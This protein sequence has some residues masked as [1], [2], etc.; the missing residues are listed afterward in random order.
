MG[1]QGHGEDEEEEEEEDP[2]DAYMSAIDAEAEKQKKKAKDVESSSKELIAAGD[3]KRGERADIEEEDDQESFFRY[4]EENPNAGV[5]LTY[6]EDGVDIEYDKDGNPIPPER[7]KVIDPLPPIDHS[8]IEYRPFARNFYVEHE[9][10]AA[11]SS[12]EVA[13]LRSKFNIR[14]TGPSPPP[15]CSSFAHF[16]FNQQLMHAIKKSEYTQPTPIQA[17]AIPAG[18]AGRDIIGIAKTGSG[19][20]AAYLWP[21]LVHIMDQPELEPGDG[22]I[23]LIM[24][25]TRELSQQIQT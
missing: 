3:S 8:T 15:P 14:V 21:M 23:G 5:I 24:A 17:Q 1:G 10:I 12:Q 20:T 19:K 13:A 25:P 18:L 16:G 22:P 2:L 7:S 6:T 9:D 4:M 11:L